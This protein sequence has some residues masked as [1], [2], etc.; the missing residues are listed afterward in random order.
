[1]PNTLSKWIFSIILSQMIM[2]AIIFSAHECFSQELS[3]RLI[4]VCGDHYSDNQ[5]SVSWSVGE[6]ITETAGTGR[7]VLT[8]GFHQPRMLITKIDENTMEN[9]AIKVFPN[10]AHEQIFVETGATEQLPLYAELWDL[11]GNRLFTKSLAAKTTSFSVKPL[12]SGLYILK[13]LSKRRDMSAHFKI[14]KCR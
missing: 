3:S 14:Q 12:P 7:Y 4:A 11:K 5:M 1:M 8:Q 6:C 13:V 2:F 9:L 10:P